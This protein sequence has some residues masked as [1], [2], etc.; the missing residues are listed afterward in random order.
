MILEACVESLEEAIAAEKSGAS[1]IELCS[2]LQYDGLSPSIE[3]VKTI[4]SM[5]NIPVKVMVRPRKGNFIY[6]DEEVEWMIKYS[7]QLKKN[8]IKSI[9]TGMLDNNYKIDLVNLTKLANSIPSMDI[10]FHKAI[11]LVEDP[12]FEIR[13]LKQIINIKI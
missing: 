5:V 13:R 10:T 12:I 9:V 11:D 1:Q 3:L 6:S 2:Q 4:K 8:G 7:K